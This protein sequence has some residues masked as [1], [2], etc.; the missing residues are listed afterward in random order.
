[1]TKEIDRK[2]YFYQVEGVQEDKSRIKINTRLLEEILS[3]NQKYAKDETCDVII[4]NM[5]ALIPA[6]PKNTSLWRISKIR[7][8]DLPQ[9]YSET[10]KK[11]EPLDLATDEGLY[12]PT[13]FIIF[14]GVLIGA[15]YNHNGQNVASGLF[16]LFEKYLVTNGISNLNRIEIKSIFKSDV[17]DLIDKIPEMR[18]ISIQIATNYA[19]LLKSDDESSFGKIFAAADLVD[20]MALDLSFKMGRGKKTQKIEAFREIISIVKKIMSRDDSKGNI[21]ILNVRGKRNSGEEKYE[22]INL[23]EQL[24]VCEKRVTQIDEKTR[25]VAPVDMYIQILESYDTFAEDLKDFV[26]PIAS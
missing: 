12:E 16:T 7:K 9:K 6:K 1:M 21:K 13:H 18:G 10:K 5:D 25:A 22:R 19:K 15:E 26:S 24:M 23:L 3:S 8:S 2:I 14:D 11:A 17:Y 4:E 20:D